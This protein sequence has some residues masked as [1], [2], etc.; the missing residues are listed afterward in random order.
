MGET[1]LTM[2][3]IEKRFPGVHALK[4]CSFELKSGEVHAL[5]GEN[6]AGKST[7]MKILTGIVKK[8]RGTIVFMNEE[9]ELH[10]PKQAQDKGIAMIHQE[11]NMMPH[12]TAAENIFIGREPTRA[13]FFTNDQKQN[14]DTRE[15]FARLGLA[16]DPRTKVENITVAGQQMIEIAKALSFQSK[17]LI[18]DEPTA[19]LTDKEIAD[20]FK[21]IRDLKTQGVGIIYISHRMDELMKITDRITVMR[22][23]EYIKTINTKYTST[24]E[25]IQMM[26]GRPIFEPPKTVSE[27]NDEIVLSVHGLHTSRLKDVSFQL[28]KGEI[29]GFA[30]LMGAGRTDVA[31]AIFGA[32]PITKG[33]I[34]VHGKPARIHSPKDAVRLGIGYLSEDR[35]Q[36]GLAL[37]M[38]VL[39]NTVLSSLSRFSSFGFIQGKKIAQV[40][41]KYIQKLNTKTPGLLSDVKNLSGGNQQKVII[42]KWLVQNCDILIF[43][44]PTRG[45]DIGAK[46][47]IYKLL[48]ELAAEGKSIIMISSELPEILRM[49]DRVAVMCEGRITGI[50]DGSD[51][52]Q[53]TIMKYATLRETTQQK[54]ENAR[55]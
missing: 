38:S 24:E 5:V 2:K 48:Y 40:A 36:F 14:K 55:E 4:Q 47:E 25:I 20:L 42:A 7:L 27:G 21:I 52:N 33:N 35:K 51:L 17:I 46:N 43:D 30:G 12:L 10:S 22:D 49:S 1:I 45:I 15:L 26:V 23:G 32:D 29:L 34:S 8:D 39:D 50:L 41:K 19:A 9:L 31:R 18:M 16:L 11:L 3:N 44:E 54:G 28:R 6:G 53:E 13:S 37:G